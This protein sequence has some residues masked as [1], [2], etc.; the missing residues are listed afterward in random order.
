MAIM[1]AAC[2]DNKTA[3]NEQAAPNATELQEQV[4]KKSATAMLLYD[5]VEPGV[6]PYQ[7]RIIVNDDFIRIDENSDGNDFVL[8]DRKKEVVYSVSNDNDA[9]LVVNRQPVDMPAPMELKLSIDKNSDENAPQI[10]GKNVVHYVFRVNGEACNDAMVAEGLLMNTTQA[11]SEYRHIL[12]GQHAS[13]LKAIPADVRNACDMASHIFHP[14]R[15]LQYGLPIQESDYSG[16]KRSLVDFDDDWT[17]DPKLFVLPAEF[18][19]FTIDDMKP[20]AAVEG[21]EATMAA[22]QENA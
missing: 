8:V 7:S 2:G 20:A 17:A 14:A 13:T 1:L 18:G 19:R 11:L 15:H 3:Q 21:E 4:K 22:S 12:A 16:Y 10:D 9:I 6:D 5:V